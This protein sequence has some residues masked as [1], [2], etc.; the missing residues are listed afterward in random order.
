MG[1]IDRN[2]DGHVSIGE[3]AF[4]HEMYSEY[5]KANGGRDPMDGGG[6]SGCGCGTGCGIFLGAAIGLTLILSSCS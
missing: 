5:E 6:G 3:A 1:L 2:G 4:A